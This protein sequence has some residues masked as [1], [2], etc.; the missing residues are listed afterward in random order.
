[1]AKKKTKKNQKKHNYRDSLFVDMFG[2]CKQAKE[3][4][5]SLYNAIH[6]TN[7]K[8][9]EVKIEPVTLKNVA[10]TKS[11]HGFCDSYENFCT[12][13][14]LFSLTPHP[15]GAFRNTPHGGG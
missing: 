2:K 9:D 4:F 11:I 1:M 13:N 7:L 6:D 10:N 15:C 8:I 14:S 3:N 5:L 12:K